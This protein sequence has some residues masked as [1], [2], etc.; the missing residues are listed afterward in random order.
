LKLCPSCGKNA[1]DNVNF[2]PDCGGNLNSPSSRGGLYNPRERSA[3]WY[4]APLLLGLIGGIIAYLII[5]NDDPQKA[6]NC[7]IIGVILTVIG[8]IISAAAG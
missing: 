2:C 5:K 7:L 8:L 1:P 6:K 4:L 3:W